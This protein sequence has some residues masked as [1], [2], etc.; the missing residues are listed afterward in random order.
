MN[1]AGRNWRIFTI[2]LVIKLSAAG[3][4]SEACPVC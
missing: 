2:C 3:I 4:L 1:A